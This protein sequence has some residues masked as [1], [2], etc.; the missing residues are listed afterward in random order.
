[1][2]EERI[3]NFIAF[4][5]NILNSFYYVLLTGRDAQRAA[6]ANSD[7]SPRLRFGSQGE[8]V[9]VVQQK[10]QAL[11]FYEG[12]LDNDFGPRMLRAVLDFQ[13]AE[14]GPTTTL[15]SVLESPLQIR[16]FRPSLFSTSSTSWSSRPMMGFR[17]IGGPDLPR[18]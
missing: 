5:I 1:M 8:L 2:S 12:T 11:D 3:F 18:C 17:G 14:F 10:L 13:T 15:S 16:V 6:R 7:L 9:R 4:S